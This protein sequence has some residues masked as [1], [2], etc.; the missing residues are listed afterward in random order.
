MPPNLH[1]CMLL[2]MTMWL[3]QAPPD[4]SQTD[5][6][7]H[8]LGQINHSTNFRPF[9]KAVDKSVSKLVN[10]AV[11]VA[12]ATGAMSAAEAA[13]SQPAA[14]LLY[15][16]V[17]W[18]MCAAALKLHLQVQGT[19]DTA[20]VFTPGVCSFETT[21][22]VTSRLC[23]DCHRKQEKCNMWAVGCR[24]HAAP[25]LDLLDSACPALNAPSH[26]G[27]CYILSCAGAADCAHEMV[28]IGGLVCRERPGGTV[29]VCVC[30]R[31]G[32]SGGTALL[33]L[34]LRRT[35]GAHESLHG[36]VVPGPLFLL[37]VLYHTLLAADV[38]S[39]TDTLAL[40]AVTFAGWGVCRSVQ[41]RRGCRQDR[42]VGTSRGS[43]D[44]PCVASCMGHS[45]KDRRLLQLRSTAA[46]KGVRWIP[47]VTLSGCTVKVCRTRAGLCLTSSWLLTRLFLDYS[48]ELLLMDVAVAVMPCPVSTQESSMPPLFCLVCVLTIGVP[49]AACSLALLAGVVLRCIKSRRHAC[50]CCLVMFFLCGGAT[51]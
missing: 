34:D 21:E 24:T 46:R 11:T 27:T 50:I 49:A 22:R 19:T 14:T 6:A 28:P 36:A 26:S 33:K 44:R 47:F 16:N 4:I 37:S 17:L 5:F 42:C 10:N 15:E 45:S 51:W 7:R 2:P 35:C 1:A 30:R 48:T 31:P 3:P 41:P 25:C 20:F 38:L 23:A 29:A 12:I 13:A 39:D 40:S 43:K 9:I 8:M 18:D 32:E